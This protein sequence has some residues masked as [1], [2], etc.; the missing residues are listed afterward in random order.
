MWRKLRIT[1]DT[2]IVVVALVWGTWE[3]LHDGRP[4]VLTLVGMMLASPIAL[5]VDKLG[6][7]RESN[8]SEI[9]E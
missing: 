3:I 7:K 9:A 1:R 4:A 2:L 6:Q 5:R 8:N